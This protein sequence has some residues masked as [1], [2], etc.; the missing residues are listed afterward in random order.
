MANQQQLPPNIIK[1][2]ILA[3]LLIFIFSIL[4]NTT[5]LTIQPGKK[6]VEFKRF[7]GGLDKDNIYDQG[8]HIIM[9]WNKVFIYD[10]RTNE[11]FETMDVLSKNGL[12]IS[13]ELSYRYSPMPDKIGYLHDEIG[14]EYV[15]RILMPEIRSATREVIGQY[16]PEELYST[17]REAIQDE[18]FQQT[19][20]GI[21]PKHL[22]IDAVLI[23][24]VKLPAKL[25]EAIEQKLKEEQLSLQYEYKLDRERQEAE[26]RII[27]AQAKADANRILNASLTDKILKDKGI[28]ATLEL[29]KS[30]NTKTVIIGGAE[31]GLPLILNNQ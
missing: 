11:G 10:V 2:G 21:G 24:S 3:F 13:V 23:R 22:I 4:S 20:D 9:P 18:I 27:E 7:G 30:P 6:G 5:F 28:E 14:T 26:R 8:F 19:A 16:L 25:E 1:Y 31:G 17:K 29:A 15:K 12:N